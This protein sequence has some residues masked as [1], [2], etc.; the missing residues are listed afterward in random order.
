[1]LDT[2]YFKEYRKL[3]GFTNQ[4]NTKDFLGAKDIIPSIDYNYINI[5]NLRL[6]GIIKKIDSILTIRN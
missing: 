2:E 1:M 3:L 6:F 4:K 5:L